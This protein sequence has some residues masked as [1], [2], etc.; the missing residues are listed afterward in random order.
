[1]SKYIPI[2]DHEIDIARNLYNAENEKKLTEINKSEISFIDHGNL[3]ER[4]IPIK[5]YYRP[6]MIHLAGQGVAVSAWNLEKE[7]IWVHR[8]KGEQR[9][10][11]GSETSHSTHHNGTTDTNRLDMFDDRGSTNHRSYKSHNGN[12]KYCRLHYHPEGRA[13]RHNTDRGYQ[14]QMYPG[15]HVFQ[16]IHR[17]MTTETMRDN[18][19]EITTETTGDT[20]TEMN[21]DNDRQ[22]YRSDYNKDNHTYDT[23]RIF[24]SENYSSERF[25]ERDDRYS[26]DRYS[27]TGDYYYYGRR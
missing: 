21:R 7:I 18:T 9:L 6:D 11:T 8:R 1:M 16:D 27:D 23:Q 17:E 20:I 4:G 2:G 15:N 22:Y 19:T 25:D 3:A 14:P 26:G 10:E 13:K 24:N 12:G 5:D